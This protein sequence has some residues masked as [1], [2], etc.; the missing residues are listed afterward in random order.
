MTGVGSLPRAWRAGALAVGDAHRLQPVQR[1]VAVLGYTLATIA[2]GG[3]LPRQIVL[4]ALYDALAVLSAPDQLELA[5]LYSIYNELKSLKLLLL[6]LKKSNQHRAI[7]AYN[8]TA[9]EQHLN[10][11]SSLYPPYLRCNI[12]ILL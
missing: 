5:I 6:N 9:L 10:S 3:K 1:I 7:L 2:Q 12:Q 8:P 11:L 4:I